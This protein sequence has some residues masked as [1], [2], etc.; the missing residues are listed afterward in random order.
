MTHKNIKLVGTSHIA[1]QS[2]NE[3]KVAI[4]EFK[5]DIIAV[6]LDKSRYEAM[7]KKNQSRLG[8]YAIRKIGLK[9]FLFAV[10]G[11]WLTKRLGK[12]VNVKPG[13]DM[14][15][16]IRLAKKNKLKLSFIDQHIQITLHR[17]SKSISIGEKLNF[18]FDVFR[19]IFF[20]KKMQKELGIKTLD[21]SKVPSD[22]LIK[23]LLGRIR[24]RYPNLYRVL[25]E[26]R[27]QVMASNLINISNQNPGK[28]ILAVVGAGHT[29]GIQHLL[30][31]PPVTYSFTFT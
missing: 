5:P 13:A 4:K 12:I 24:I 11:S 8:I 20:R 23:R 25:V 3:V 22:T 19:A 6:E 26:E 28:K 18:F 14:M 15:T 9:G 16:A 10:I 27:N 17:L 1:Q 30:S 2:I 31:E 29:E 7:L 21:L